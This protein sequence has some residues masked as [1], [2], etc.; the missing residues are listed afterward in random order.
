MKL[1]LGWWVV[2]ENDG[3]HCACRE[4]KGLSF[5]GG[6]GPASQITH[7]P[8]NEANQ[9]H[10]SI[11][12]PLF[13]DEP[14]IVF[15]RLEDD[16]L[17]YFT[18]GFLAFSLWRNSPRRMKIRNRRPIR[19]PMVWYYVGTW[20]VSCLCLGCC[21]NAQQRNLQSWETVGRFNETKVAL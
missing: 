8:S 10:Q 6:Q 17:F 21:R 11:T 1:V 12:N 3:P 16:D 5:R 13:A 15:G 19:D 9:T 20:T 4:T 18:R 2:S 7:D 14:K